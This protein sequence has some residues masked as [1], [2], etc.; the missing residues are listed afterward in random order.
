MKSS[1]SSAVTTRLV[2]LVLFVV[3]F[4]FAKGTC[5]P[6]YKGARLTNKGKK[7]WN[8]AWSWSDTDTKHITVSECQTKC[9]ESKTC[10]G[11]EWRASRFGAGCSL[12]KGTKKMNL[13]KK[14]KCDMCDAF[15]GLCG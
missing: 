8:R 9:F 10:E 11:W 12:Y 5:G 2:L 13:D 14:Y 15:A 3:T 1:L 6:Q 4:A 7:I